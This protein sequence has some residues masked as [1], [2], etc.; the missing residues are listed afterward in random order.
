M[1]QFNLVNLRPSVYGVHHEHLLDYIKMMPPRGKVDAQWI[2][3]H[4]TAFVF[5]YICHNLLI[6]FIGY[7]FLGRLAGVVPGLSFLYPRQESN[8]H[9]LTRIKGSYP[10]EDATLGGI[11]SH[12]RHSDYHSLAVYFHCHPGGTIVLVLVAAILSIITDFVGKPVIARFSKNLAIKCQLI[13]VFI[14]LTFVS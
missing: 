11:H 7:K 3:G 2:S 14:Y 13:V 1:V 10:G 8:L 6:G 5:F 4:V 9:L 12:L